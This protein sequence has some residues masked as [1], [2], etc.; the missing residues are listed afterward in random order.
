[1]LSRF[2]AGFVFAG[3]LCGV[4]CADDPRGNVIRPKM[5]DAAVRGCR[6]SE[7]GEYRATAGD[8]IELE[9][10]FPIVPTAIPKDVSRQWDQG[11]IGPSKLG[12]RSLIVPKTVGTG[13]YVFCFEARQEGS[14]RAVV[15][16]DG[17]KY[18]YRFEVSE[19]EETEEPNEQ[20]P[21]EAV[22]SN[23]Y[24]CGTGLPGAPTLTVDW[25]TDAGEKTVSGEGTLTQAVRPPVNL[26]VKMD[27][28]YQEDGKVT[29]V[30]AYGAAPGGAVQLVLS[31]PGGWAKPG[32]A[33]FRWY[34]KK[35]FGDSG[36]NVPAAP[37][38]EEP[39]QSVASQRGATESPD[40]EEEAKADAESD[41]TSRRRVDDLERQLSTVAQQLASVAKSVEGL[42]HDRESLAGPDPL[43]G[44][45]RLFAGNFPPRG[46]AFCDG[47]LLAISQHSALFSLLGTT[48]GG[49]GRTTFGLP[50]LRGR[51]AVHPG[52]GPGLTAIRLGERGGSNT[53]NLSVA[54]M[55]YRSIKL[56][57][58]SGPE[59]SN[60]SDAAK[61][62]EN[63]DTKE[64]SNDDDHSVVSE[65]SAGGGQPINNMQPYQGVHYIIALQGI[66]PSRD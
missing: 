31:L 43:L 8:V 57:T 59:G 51:V 24:R 40:P 7:P 45:I 1:M 63:A 53:T 26:R 66:Y 29:E 46:W 17:E 55:P 33:D 18:E 11:A 35:R 62:R 16:I 23:R 5:V 44:E 60:A 61:A 19:V 25:R 22:S 30:V 39:R 37:D 21:G 14:G 48:F 3:L 36:G 49:D 32:K 6:I 50:G 28:H 56:R 52:R 54:N 2:I 10:T 47:Q 38:S 58:E 27:G 64:A 15:V 9:Y 20:Q 42:K 65:Q 13:T 34:A 41:R 4:A 12:I